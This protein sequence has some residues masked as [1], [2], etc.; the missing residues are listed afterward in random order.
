[1]NQHHSDDFDPVTLRQAL[2][3]YAT[4]VAILTARNAAGK[5]VGLTV[6][7]FAAVSL[8]PP[9]VLWS[10]GRQSQ[11]IE[12]FTTCSHWTVNV[13]G[14]DQKPLAERFSQPDTERFASLEWKVGAGGTPL[15]AGCSAWFECRSEAH[16]AGGDHLILLGRI[17]R[18]ASHSQPPLLFHGSRYLTLGDPA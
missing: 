10:L 2:G 16:Y 3:E 7:S 17:E 5:P 13:L 9:L 15:L 4:G 12:T 6:N 1:M 11:L 18:Y 14:A 8:D